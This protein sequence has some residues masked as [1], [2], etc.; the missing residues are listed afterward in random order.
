EENLADRESLAVEEDL[1]IEDGTPGEDLSPEGCTPGETP[2]SKVFDENG[3]DET[4]PS[5][6]YKEE[7]EENPGDEWPTTWPE[8]GI[9]ARIPRPDFDMDSLEVNIC[10]ENDFMG[11][12]KA[13]EEDYETYILSCK[14]Y[15]FTFEEETHS[16]REGDFYSAGFSAFDID[17]YKITVD[18]YSFN[19]PEDDFPSHLSIRIKAPV[20]LGTLNWPDHALGLL[21]P[22]PPTSVGGAGGDP[23]IFL[24]A[25]L[26]QMSLET[27]REYVEACREAGFDQNI[28]ETEREYTATDEDGIRLTISYSGGNMVDLILFDPEQKWSSRGLGDSL[29][30][31]GEGEDGSGLPGEPDSPDPDSSGAD[32]TEETDGPDGTENPDETAKTDDTDDLNGTADPDGADKTPGENTGTSGYENPGAGDHPAD[33]SYE[34]TIDQQDARTGGQPDGG[35]SNQFDSEA[36]EENNG[37]MDELAYDSLNEETDSLIED[38]S[39]QNPP[40]GYSEY[41]LDDQGLLIPEESDSETPYTPKSTDDPDL[42]ESGQADFNNT[43]GSKNEA[44]KSAT[45]KSDE[46]KNDVSKKDYSKSEPAAREPGEV[47]VKG[48]DKKSV[49]NLPL[50]PADGRI[51]ASGN[52]DAQGR[53]QYAQVLGQSINSLLPAD[54]TGNSYIL[55][56]PAARKLEAALRGSPGNP[57]LVRSGIMIQTGQY[58]KEMQGAGSFPIS[59][60][61]SRNAHS[62]ESRI[63]LPG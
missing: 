49:D 18:Y 53:K 17:G 59:G 29:A 47:L 45:S 10:M 39:L 21:I 38:N 5:D 28:S 46:S 60:R 6:E 63:T 2:D 30:G 27:W 33:Q 54:S 14:E 51:L 40:D 56:G 42:T 7:Y 43:F 41:I 57:L 32:E 36:A 12:V 9:T 25:S 44:S 62:Q 31:G 58:G 20:Q 4:D 24:R 8:D 35:T 37:E 61:N 22:Q 48:S 23:E 50:I 11:T 19:D 15:G 55:S 52:A 13:T 26:G 16:S 3:T 1:N 34:E